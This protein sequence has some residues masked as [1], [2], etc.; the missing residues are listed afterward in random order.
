MADKTFKSK[1]YRFFARESIMVDNRIKKSD[2]LACL[3]IVIRQ[4]CLFSPD[5]TRLQRF[6]LL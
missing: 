6:A 5:R 4:Y 3:F 1:K 2:G